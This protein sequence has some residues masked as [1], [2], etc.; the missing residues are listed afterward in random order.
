MEEERLFLYDIKGW[1]I[2]LSLAELNRCSIALFNNTFS[3]GSFIVVPNLTV[4]RT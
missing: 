4:S 2:A 3:A 1:T